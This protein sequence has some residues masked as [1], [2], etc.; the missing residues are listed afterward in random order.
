MSSSLIRA[1][2]EN[3]FFIPLAKEFAVLLIAVLLHLFLRPEGGL[4]DHRA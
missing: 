4:N 3:F 2:G 1:K